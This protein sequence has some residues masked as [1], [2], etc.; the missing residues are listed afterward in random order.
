MKMI[1]H[2]VMGDGCIWKG[3]SL[4]NACWVNQS[5]FYQILNAVS[6]AVFKENV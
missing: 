3:I 5:V 4:M 6:Y 2:R 1:W